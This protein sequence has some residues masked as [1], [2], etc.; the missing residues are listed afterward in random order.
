MEPIYWNSDSDGEILGIFGP[1][2]DEA[3]AEE[4]VR[5]WGFVRYQPDSRELERARQ[6]AHDDPCSPSVHD[7][8]S[9]LEAFTG[10]LVFIEQEGESRMVAR[11]VNFRDDPMDSPH[12]AETSKIRR[13]SRGG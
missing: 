8:V 6:D 4:K 9:D 11:V 7:A 1:F 13:W 12:Q 5:S 2:T 3:S 10:H